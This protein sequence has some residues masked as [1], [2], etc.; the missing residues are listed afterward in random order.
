MWRLAPST[1]INSKSK[2]SADEEEDKRRKIEKE[3]A[4]QRRAEQE[5]QEE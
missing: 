4:T 2:T 3:K 1:S 5:I